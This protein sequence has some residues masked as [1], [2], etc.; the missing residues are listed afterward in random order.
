MN[1]MPLAEVHLHNLQYSTFHNT[2]MT[3]IRNTEF[4][5]Q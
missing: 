1:I 2:N 5:Q 3:V 4:L